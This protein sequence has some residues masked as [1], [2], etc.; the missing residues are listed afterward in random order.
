MLSQ[1]K[2]FIEIPIKDEKYN[3]KIFPHHS[4]FALKDKIVSVDYDYELNEAYVR[5][6][7][8]YHFEDDTSEIKQ[9]VIAFK[10]TVEFFEFVGMLNNFNVF[11]PKWSDEERC[12]IDICYK[13]DK[14]MKDIN[15][16][17]GMFQIMKVTIPEE[18]I[19]KTLYYAINL[20]YIKA[21]F[22]SEKFI[23][24]AE[25]NQNGGVK[26]GGKGFKYMSADPEKKFTY[27]IVD[28]F[29]IYG[30]MCENRLESQI[31]ATETPIE[32]LL[33]LL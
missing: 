26:R 20:R 32:E 2:R 9:R 3:E 19:M 22:K 33:M 18:N 25:G 27:M 13:I 24:I 4:I 11:P 31:M 1:N 23:H 7:G 28:I 17:G 15:S 12:H 6:D 8:Y 29:D 14:V 16:H 5:L 30:V 10:T 21:V